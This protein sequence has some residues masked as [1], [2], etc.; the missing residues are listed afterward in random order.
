MHDDAVM[1]SALAHYA[2][3]PRRCGLIHLEQVFDENLFTL[4]ARAIHEA[5]DRPSWAHVDS[6]RLERALPLWCERHGLYG[7][8]DVVEF[9]ADGR[10]YPVEQKPGRVPARPDRGQRAEAIQLCAQALCLEEMLQR[11]VDAGAVYYFASRRRLDVAID[12]DL[13]AR[14]LEVL[15]RVRALLLG[16]ALPEPVAD[17][18]CRNCSLAGACVPEVLARARLDWHARDLYEV[19]DEEEP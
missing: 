9:H 14:T 8:G 6:C 15:A 4:R 16:R 19:N 13:R 12:A 7:V 17:A 1:I 11:P 3:C 5:V 10:A 18:R 2:Y